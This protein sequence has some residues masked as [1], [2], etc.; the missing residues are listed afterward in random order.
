MNTANYELHVRW[1]ARPERARACAVRLAST[2]EGL[3]NAHSAFAR[4]NKLAKS[5]AAA[6]K[7]AWSMPPEIDE[8]ADVFERGRQY[9]DIPR[10]PWPEMGYSVYAWNGLSPPYGASLSVRA[11]LFADDRAFPNSVDLDV[12][13]ARL[14]DVALSSIAVLKP[15]LLCFVAAW[16]PDNGNVVCW[17]YWRRLFGGRRYP[18]FRSGWMTYL[19]PQ[20]T[21]RV[22]PP[23]GAI[24][25]S[26][27]GGGL[28][29]LATEE[30]FSMD[31]PEH[32]AVADAI[33]AAL[34]PVQEMISER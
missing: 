32:L 16:E 24:V 4:W 34:A 13:P 19:A 33:Q 25:E 28:L 29:L 11:G 27:P 1:R 18:P 8:L 23:P 14:E 20:Y 6:N 10:D 17:D 30:R 2:L 21:S 22:S 9:R 12:D 3:A 15:A 7:P 26:V 5:R 31:N